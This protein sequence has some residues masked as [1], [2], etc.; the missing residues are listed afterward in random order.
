MIS[1]LCFVSAGIGMGVQEPG[2]WECLGT[3]LRQSAWEKRAEWAVELLVLHSGLKLEVNEPE[4]SQQ[5]FAVFSGFL[6]CCFRCFLLQPVVL[7]SV[8]C[9]TQC[10][11][12]CLCFSQR[13][14]RCFHWQCF[15]L[16]VEVLVQL[17]NQ[18][19]HSP[20]NQVCA[21]DSLPASLEKRRSE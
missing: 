5:T 6:R 15:L 10:C 3:L 2:P 17:G 8:L 18:N 19:F 11:F 9:F 4:V 14:F 20:C 7:S 1:W 12:P 16:F 13:F 21:L